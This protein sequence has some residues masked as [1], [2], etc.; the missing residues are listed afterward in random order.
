MAAC[1]ILVTC[2]G[3]DYA[4]GSVAGRG[5]PRAAT[6]PKPFV[7]TI[8]VTTSGK[9]TGA[10]TNHYV[11]LSFEST[12]LNA[13][14]FDT[15]GNLPQLLKNLGSGTM[16][17]GGLSVDNDLNLNG[18]PLWTGVSA[19]GLAGLVRLVRASGWTVFYSEDL[20]DFPADKAQVTNDAAKVAAG[21]GS[22]LA[23]IGCGNEPDGYVRYAKRPAG[24][25]PAAYPKDAA[26]CLAAIRQGAPK[27]PLGGPDLVGGQN[28]FDPYVRQ[29]AGK[30]ALAGEHLYPG[31]ARE[32]YTGQ[33]SSSVAAIL[34]SAPLVR[35]KETKT[36]QWVTAG[37]K[38]AKAKPIMS[39]TNSISSGGMPGVS[40]TFTA[41]LWA[42]NYS[43]LGAEYGMDGMN[44]HN[45]FAGTC[46]AYSEIC[47]GASDPREFT[48]RPI[49]YGLLFTHLLGTGKFLP[50]KVSTGA[51][52][53]NVVAYALKP[54]SG[55]PH[56]MVENL[57]A[58]PTTITLAVGGKAASAK[59]L[60]LTAPGLLAK[61]GVRI[62]GAAVN[63]TTGVIKVGAPTVIKCSQGK[64][65]LTLPA[66]AAAIVTI[67]LQVSWTR[68]SRPAAEPPGR[69]AAR[70]GLDPPWVVTAG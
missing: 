60:R 6:A 69:R 51:T 20:A 25:G 35:T 26:A 12:G 21:L 7:S 3:T 52:A 54:A 55:G 16:R 39:E 29:E 1:V 2:V 36:F 19:Q 56:V 30:L 45:M 62:Q 61:S 17:F 67:P 66:Y 38:L 47:P 43:L 23:A 10:I 50:V 34:L 42:I 15:G 28:W 11:G 33:S 48:V 64:C 41:A 27:A 31:A 32:R 18:Y 70:D 63:A 59:V 57:T 8:T 49:Y 5:S 4:G 9:T 53:R 58:Q 22:R 37:A 46:A 65:R 68:Y 40:D 14:N 24:Y 13:G 44:F